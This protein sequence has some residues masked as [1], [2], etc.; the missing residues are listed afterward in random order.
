MSLRTLQRYRR[1]CSAHGI[2]GLVDKR[3][4]R[5]STVTG[6]VDDCYVDALRR[7]AMENANWSTGTSTRLKRLVDKNVDRV[8]HQSRCR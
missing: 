3:A 7:V 1:D 2:E 5:R 4:V 8:H 6:R